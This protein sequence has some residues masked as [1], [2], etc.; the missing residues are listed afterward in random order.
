[1]VSTQVYNSG[2]FEIIESAS[3]KNW[4]RG[5]RDREAKNRINGR[6]KTVASG[7]VGDVSSVGTG[8]W[9]LRIHYGPGYR[10]YFIREGHRIIVLLSGGDKST[11]RQDIMRSQ[12]LAEE[13]RRLR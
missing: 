13:W 9:E 4:I 6:L 7:N 1:M 12:T 2:V 5:L 11:Q 8:L 10:V 3:F